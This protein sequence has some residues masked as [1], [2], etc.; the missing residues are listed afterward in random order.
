MFFCLFVV[1]LKKSWNTLGCLHQKDIAKLFVLD[2]QLIESE[3]SFKL[4]F[5]F[6]KNRPLE[7]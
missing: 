5:N 2:E 7:S 1:W 6:K 3:N 4:H